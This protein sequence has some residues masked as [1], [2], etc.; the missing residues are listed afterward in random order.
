[1]KGVRSVSELLILN[2]DLAAGA[3]CGGYALD[4]KCRYV[5]DAHDEGLRSI[6]LFEL[7]KQYGFPPAVKNWHAWLFKHG[8]SAEVPN[9]TNSSVAKYYGVKPLWRTDYSQG[10]VVRAIDEDDYFVVMECGHACVGYVHLQI[11]LTPGGCFD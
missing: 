1:M 4:P 7:F 8:F 5:I 11:L 6:K 10:L 3:A 2:S 9:L